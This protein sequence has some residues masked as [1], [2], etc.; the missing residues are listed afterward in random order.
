MLVALNAS[1]TRI[2]RFGDPE[3]SAR[4]P[5]SKRDNIKLGGMEI[6]RFK[7]SRRLMSIPAN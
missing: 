6:I 5:P 1:S 4:A 3:A 2:M 7:K